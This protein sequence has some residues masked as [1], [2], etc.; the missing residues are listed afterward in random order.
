MPGMPGR[1]QLAKGLYEMSFDPTQQQPPEQGPY[2]EYGPVGDSNSSSYSQAPYGAPQGG[3]NPY[4]AQRAYDDPYG[5]PQATPLPLGE[6][7]A[8]L[9]GQYWKVL[10]R[11]GARSLAQEVGKAN[12]DIIWVQLIGYAL[13]A[14]ILSFVRN[15]LFPVVL[16]VQTTTTASGTTTVDLTFLQGPL[17]FI[18]GPG[19][20]IVTLL[21]FFIFQGIS[22]GLAKAFRG[23][24]T[25]PAQAYTMLLF[26]VP[27]GI[28]SVVFDFIPI[29]GA[30]VGLAAGVYQIVLSIFAIMAAHRLG[31]GKATGVILIPIGVL[32][33]LACCVFFFVILS[34]VKTTPA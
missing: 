15:R 21:G 24:G 17:N 11:P 1:T 34:A 19:A 13:I 28:L 32:T 6:A 27:L 10:T 26:Q 3:Y 4:N 14:G 31:G 16:P 7:V 5:A 30:L 23:T 22:Y 25:F 29:A 2:V 12:W 9:P 33:L 8:Q 18:E 20:I